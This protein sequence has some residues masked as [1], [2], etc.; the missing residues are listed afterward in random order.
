MTTYGNTNARV[1]LSAAVTGSG[2]SVAPDGHRTHF[3]AK[4]IALTQDFKSKR[5]INP[6]GR[7]WV[8][9]DGKFDQGFLIQDAKFVGNVDVNG[10]KEWI[11]DA[12]IAQTPIYAIVK[13]PPPTGTT[14][15]TFL[16][17]NWTLAKV[18]YL[19]GVIGKLKFDV[20]NGRLIGASFDF[21]SAWNGSA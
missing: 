19:K 14:Y 10:T 4:K 21:G 5:K 6:K 8:S 18:Y 13:L 7:T 12:Y 3:L 9:T 15:A 16:W 17:Y 20:N 2:V 1:T 11:T